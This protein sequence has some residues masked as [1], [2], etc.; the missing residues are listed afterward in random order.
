MGVHTKKCSEIRKKLQFEKSSCLPQSLK[1]MVLEKISERSGQKGAGIR[2]SSEEKISKNVEF[3]T[4][5]R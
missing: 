2:M 4:L 5:M 3:S 1:T